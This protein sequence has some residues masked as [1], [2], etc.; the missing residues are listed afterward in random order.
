MPLG[1]WDLDFLLV[2]P[3]LAASRC[4]VADQTDQAISDVVPIGL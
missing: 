3:T 4:E 1:N 2:E